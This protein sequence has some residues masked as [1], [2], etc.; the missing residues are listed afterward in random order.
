MNET[1]PDSHRNPKGRWYAS[2]TFIL[3]L[4]M[5]TILIWLVVT[6]IELRTFHIRPTLL[7]LKSGTCE[8][9]RING[10]DSKSSGTAGNCTALLP[11][12]QNV[13]GNGGEITLGEK[14]IRIADDQVVI[15]GA[16]EYRPWTR[17]QSR[18]ALVMGL[19]TLTV[20]GMLGWMI[21]RLK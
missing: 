17:E 7:T 19:A 3:I 6:A 10:I 12:H 9:L 18:A 16:I 5:H 21:S 13:F 2:P 8:Y 20:L 15:V 1:H 11:F 4:T 14:Q